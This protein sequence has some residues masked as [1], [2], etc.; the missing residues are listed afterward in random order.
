MSKSLDGIDASSKPSVSMSDESSAIVSSS[1]VFRD[2]ES[3]AGD[4]CKAQ[5]CLVSNAMSGSAPI[6]PSSVRVDFDGSLR[7]IVIEHAT[8]STTAKKAGAASIHAVDLKE[9]FPED[10]EEDLPV[11][12]QGQC[13]LTLHPRQK[14]VLEL[15]IPLRE[16]GD[17]HPS[18]VILWCK[19]QSF[20]LDYKMLFRDTDPA[21]GWHI[22]G[23]SKPRQ[24]RSDSRSLHVAPRPP[25][26][27]IKVVEPLPQY[28]ANESITVLVTLQNDEDEGVHVK[29]DAEFY[30]KDIPIIHLKAGDQELSAEAQAKESR[31]SAMPLGSITKSGSKEISLIIDP[32]SGPVSYDI[33]LKATYHLESDAATPI[34]QILP[35]QLNLV[36]AFEANYDL[37]PRLHVEPWPSLFDYEGLDEAAGS[38]SKQVQA[39][40]LA[41]KW[42]LSCHFASFAH[43]DIWVDKTDLEV[44]ACVGGAQC[45]IAK[46]SKADASGLLVGPKT[47]H[48][49]QFELVAQ[50]N[51]LED[52]SPVSVD[53]SFI[54]RWRRHDSPEGGEVNTTV[55]PVGRYLVLGTE[56]RVLAS[57]LSSGLEQTSTLQLDITIENPSNHLLTFG[58]SMEPSDEF[59]FSG[60]KQTTIHLL[61][62]SRRTTTYRLLPLKRGTYIRPGLGVRD[63]YFQKVLRIIPTEGMKIDKDGLLVW[64]P[65]PVDESEG[66]VDEAS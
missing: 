49:A 66:N 38:D 23:S 58:L 6:T 2:K 44:T 62:M 65:G 33:N 12:L 34:I 29:F 47:M 56:P 63:K 45:N 61:P 18:S 55:M 46:V 1:F 41:Q 43:E 59:A 27:E 39:R 35:L 5:L 64:V 57:V 52:R 31:I 25:K 37:V 21:S 3:K 16:S 14:L 13:D 10:A 9:E 53:L 8:N 22:P 17:V 36:S 4:T 7:P 51:H 48:E 30:G 28:Y 26:L 19:T 32:A 24:A 60:A 20:D 50:K 15:E 40:G 11:M 54:I 42:S